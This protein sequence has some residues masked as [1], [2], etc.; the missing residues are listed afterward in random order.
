MSSSD[1]RDRLRRLRREDEAPAAGEHGAGADRANPA[2]ANPARATDAAPKAG[3]PSWLRARLA[4]QVE[5]AAAQIEARY[6][7]GLVLSE[8]DLA[9]GLPTGLASRRG[10][11]GEVWARETGYAADALH[12]DWRL[13]ELAEADV[14]GVALLARDSSLA[15]VDLSQAVF[16]DTETTG[17]SGGAGT[18][19]Y[20]IGLGA[21]D[22][23]GEFHVW[24][25]FLRGPGEERALL[26]EAAERIA[27]AS[28]VVSFFGKSFDRH[29]LE[30]KMRVVGVAPPFEELPHLDLY[31]PFQ[32]L[33]K[34]RLPDGR[35]ATMES[36]LCGLVREDD[37]P[38]ALAPAAWFDFLADRA[39]RLEGV[40]RHNLLD[41]VSLVTLAA[42][43]GRVRS[44]Q[45][46][47]GQALAG[48][49]VGRARGIARALLDEGQR[50]PA[51]DWLE[52]AAQRAAE[53][54]E[55]ARDL[56]FARGENLRRMGRPEEAR[57]FLEDVIAC[58]VTDQPWSQAVE[59]LLK[60]LEH[61]LH[62][63]DAARELCAASLARSRELRP[64]LLRQ[65]FVAG[66]EKRVARLGS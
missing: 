13:A 23:A 55:D 66:L 42:Y 7:A 12:G 58:P 62:Q 6:P 47:D 16:L 46:S 56:G 31:H 54:G 17:L 4:G 35:L 38:G 36:T 32:R 50:T 8:A 48:C 25:G 19:V 52:R 51:C 61:D 5:A 21:F 65:R 14:E 63:R 44:E 37:L 40:F 1:F 9:P 28:C 64:A 27:R 24:Q 29:R 57:G 22:A 45:R 18:Y 20:M 60:L 53:V 11:A 34:G 33:T 43:L 41:V 59:A 49:A 15:H 30:D 2:R 3:M 10:P 26:A 39:H